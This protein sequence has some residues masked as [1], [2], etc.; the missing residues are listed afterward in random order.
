MIYRKARTHEAEVDHLSLMV[1]NLPS[2]EA[3]GIRLYRKASQSFQLF[4]LS[5]FSIS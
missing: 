5:G 3:Y 1:H 2:L 4:S